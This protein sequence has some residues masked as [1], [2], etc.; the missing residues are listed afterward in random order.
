M[1]KI[2]HKWEC[3][4]CHRVDETVGVSEPDGWRY[5]EKHL[6]CPTCYKKYSFI[7]ADFV[8]KRKEY[9]KYYEENYKNGVVRN[10][11]FKHSRSRGGQKEAK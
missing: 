4:R 6:L 2:V 11:K 1:E 3:D 5:V 10:R 8:S 7:F 9:D